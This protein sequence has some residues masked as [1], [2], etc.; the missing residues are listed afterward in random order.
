V[1]VGSVLSKTFGLG[2][3]GCGTANYPYD[4]SGSADFAI[5]P[6]T[7]TCLGPIPQ[8][9]SCFIGVVFSP[10]SVGRI[11]GALNVTFGSVYITAGL[12]GNG[13]SP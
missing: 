5:D 13:V 10:S 2:N 3:N 7:T 4:V 11:A 9:T 6:A 1:R 12:S 8:G